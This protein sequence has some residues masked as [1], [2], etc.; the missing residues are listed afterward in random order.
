[1]A[2]KSEDQSQ[3]MKLLAIDDEKYLTTFT[4]KYEN[5]KPYEPVD[6][7]KVRAF[8]PGTII[9]LFV[10]PGSKVK[11][12]D[13]LFVLE[14]MKMNNVI[15]SHLDGVI[16]KVNIEVNKTVANKEILIEFE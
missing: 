7:R 3:K 1:M 14:A 9:D 11:T 12:G 10:K 8:I 16:K 2:S 6:P 15:L 13:Q 5:R 4:K